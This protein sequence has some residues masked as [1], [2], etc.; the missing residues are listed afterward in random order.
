VIALSLVNIGIWIGRTPAQFLNLPFLMIVLGG[1]TAVFF[2]A[3]LWAGRKVYERRQALGDTSKN[4]NLGIDLGLGDPKRE[5]VLQAPLFSALLPFFL[6]MLVIVRLPLPNPSAVFGLAL[7]LVLM[8][9]YLVRAFGADPVLVMGLVYSLI[10]ETLWFHRSFTP[11]FALIPLGWHLVFYGVF[12]VFPFLSAARFQE[13]MIPWIV[14]AVSGPAH[15]YIIYQLL[16]R[17]YPGNPYPGLIPVVLAVP[18]FGGLI[19]ALKRVSSGHSKRNTILAL[20]GGSTLFFIT[21]IMPI[22]FDRQWITIGWALEGAALIWL[23]HRVPHPGLRLVGVLLLGVAFARLALNQRVLSYWPRSEVPILNWFLYAYGLT[24]LCL[25][26]GARLLAP[27]RNFIGRFNAPPALYSLATIL[28]FLLLNI[29]IADYFSSG[30]FVTFQ[31][32]GNIQ[33]DM[34]YSLA[35]TAFAF[36]LFIVGIMKNVRYARYAGLG[37]LTFTLLKIFLH[38]LWRLGGLYRIGS[39]VGLAIALILVSFIYQRFLVSDAN[40]KPP[41]PGES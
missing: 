39:I 35:W 40:R 27:P 41:V 21:L 25:F 16:T 20:F 12:M 5:L 4:L 8:L 15:F 3:G 18:A 36:L 13:R 17:A 38:D 11:D 26:A 22:Q 19:W 7:V 6:L 1:F 9:F 23:F 31:F 10:L 37:L 28:A 30:S 29:E 24:T 33:R 34:T 14:S 32:S 2:G